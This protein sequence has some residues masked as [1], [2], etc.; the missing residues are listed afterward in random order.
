MTRNTSEVAACCS[1]A[2]SRSRLSLSNCS[3]RSVDARALC[4]LR[5][6]GSPRRL[7]SAVR[8]HYV[9]AYRPLW[10][11]AQSYANLGARATA[12]LNAKISSVAGVAAGQS[13]W[14]RERSEADR[15]DSLDAR[16]QQIS[17][18]EHP[19]GNE[20][21]IRTNAHPEARSRRCSIG[22]LRRPL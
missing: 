8:S 2:S 21:V 19:G 11:V 16:H 6:L 9:A 20:S 5:A 4:A 13:G 10:R 14:Q 22:T 15:G 3:E 7:L 18:H 17:R 12:P 1:S